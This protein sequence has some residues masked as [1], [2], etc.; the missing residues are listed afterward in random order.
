MSGMAAALSKKALLVLG[1]VTVLVTVSYFLLGSVIDR[2]PRTIVWERDYEK[3]VERARAEGKVILAD[4]FTD[5]CVLCKDMDRETFGDPVLIRQM[6]N[7]YVWLKL[8]TETEDDGKRLQEEFAIV[9]YPLVL[10]LDSN[11]QEIDRIPNFLAAA[12]FKEAVELHLR[13]PESLGKIRERSEQNPDSVEF[14]SALG[15]KY[16]DRNNYRK[17]A[18]EFEKVIELDPVNSK[19]RTIESY[20]NV[21]LSLASQSKFDEALPYLAALEKNFPDAETIP[22]VQ[23]LRGQIYECCG[24]RNEAIGI[25]REYLRKYPGHSYV[26]Q[27]KQTL[28]ALESQD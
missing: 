18:V 14:R 6:A 27:V 15:T 4:M 8:N 9:T 10:V 13:N 2:V 24:K 22:N 7:E 19:G 28:A 25:F 21:A 16:L 26:D 3:A 5:W 20:Y 17:A 11:G 23:V 12:P 1:G